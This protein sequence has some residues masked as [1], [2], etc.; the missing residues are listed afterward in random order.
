MLHVMARGFSSEGISQSLHMQ[1]NQAI[2]TAQDTQTHTHTHTH[3]H[4]AHPSPA[5]AQMSPLTVPK[6]PTLSGELRWQHKA[7]KGNYSRRGGGAANFDA[8]ALLSEMP[9]TGPWEDYPEG[10]MPVLTAAYRAKRVK[11]SAVQPRNTIHRTYSR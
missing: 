7:D 2:H 9:R 11:V 3:T 8:P 6:L 4:T 5:L 10:T 1:I